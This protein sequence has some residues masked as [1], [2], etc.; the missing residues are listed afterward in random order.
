[1]QRGAAM[2]GYFARAFCLA[3]E[4]GGPGQSSR[5]SQKVVCATVLGPPRAGPRTAVAV[6][7]GR[8]G[9]PGHHSLAVPGWQLLS[10]KV[11]VSA[12]PRRARQHDRCEGHPA[13]R[14]ATT[15][16]MSLRFFCLYWAPVLSSPRGGGVVIAVMVNGA[17]GIRLPHLHIPLLPA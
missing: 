6:F 17:R 3:V 5:V 11:S 12:R 4:R 1:M 14:G 9:R 7:A 8:P 15:S 13:A 10:G 16:C 2:A